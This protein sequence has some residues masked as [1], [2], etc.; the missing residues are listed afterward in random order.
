MKLDANRNILLKKLYTTKNP[1]KAVFNMQ[2]GRS[3]AVAKN[4]DYIVGGTRWSG[5]NVMRLDSAGNLKWG[6]WYYDS[7]KGVTG[8]KLQGKGAINCVR[9][10]SRQ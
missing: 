5:P 10:T 8:S 2:W 3:I 4:G 9:E 1:D 6:A 7:A